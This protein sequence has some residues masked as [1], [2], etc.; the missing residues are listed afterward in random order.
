MSA[1]LRI[2][3]L[4][5][6]RLAVP[7]RLRFEHA[8][9][10]R[11]TADPIV[12]R[13][14]ALPPFG[15]LSGYGEALA[16]AYVTGETADTVADDVLQHFAPR[17]LELRAGGFAEALEFAESLPTFVDGRLVN[18][19]RCAVELALLDLAGKA[20][21]RR[22]ADAS[23]WLDM[24]GF[25]PPGALAAAR[26]SGIV[27]GRSR[28]K[29][30]ALLRA[31]RCYGLR[32][33]KLKVAVDGWQERLSWA[34]FELG[35]A[36]ARRRAT[37][38]VDANG[39][40]TPFE[41]AAAIPILKQCGVESLEQPVPR[42]ADACHVELM[43]AGSPD[44]IADESLL[45]VEDAERLIEADGVRVL[46]VRLAKNGGLLPSLRIA[47]RA[48][49]AGVDVQLGCL[50]GE[51]SIL[52]A[53]GLAFLELCPRARYVEGAFG[54][55]LLR[56]DVLRPPLTFGYGGRLAPRR[57]PGLGI[58]VDQGAIER[59]SIT[60]GVVVRF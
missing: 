48:M 35:G 4:R 15:E 20:F 19:A 18:A 59:L 25:E 12:V 26:Y 34:A 43:A 37:L 7:M 46:N 9:A 38:R 56:A 27:V 23:G 2:D 42:A 28:A 16:R 58:R 44:I 60:P 1:A 30:S 32:D 31:Q 17:L 41:A 6:Y 36:I 13:L 3:A 24:K 57:A 14:D 45:T 10:A 21:G 55:F 5:V 22:L 29:L 33:F 8:A 52:T 49:A 51:T 47:A 11:A 50:V 39:G 40:W 53:A 54:R